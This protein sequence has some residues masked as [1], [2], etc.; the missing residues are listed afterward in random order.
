[1]ETLNP[2]KLNFSMLSFLVAMGKC[3][4]DLTVSGSLDNSPLAGLRVVLEESTGRRIKS[5]GSDSTTKSVYSASSQKPG[6]S[7]VYTT[8]TPSPI[9]CS[10]ETAP[11][12]SAPYHYYV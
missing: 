3:I 10:S 6:T 11:S 12:S 7:T 4:E 5:G 9:K 8:P 2:A 1:M